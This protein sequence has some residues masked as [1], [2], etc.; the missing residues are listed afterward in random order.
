MMIRS[1]G[2]SYIL[3]RKQ[4]KKNRKKIRK[5]IQSLSTQNVVIVNSFPF[6]I[7]FAVTSMALL[8]ICGMLIM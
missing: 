6:S 2:V 4:N 5:I 3:T 7:P 1:P 8:F